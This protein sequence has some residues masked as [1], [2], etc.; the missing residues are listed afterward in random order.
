MA[1]PTRA[2]RVGVLISADFEPANLVAMHLVWPIREPQ[3]TRG[4]KRC[5]EEMIIRG[6]APTEDSDRPVDDLL[7]HVRRHD[8]DHRDFLPRRL[9]AERVHYVRRLER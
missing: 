7:G 8:L 9:V 5:G 3:Q 1:F 6:A 2:C 4:R